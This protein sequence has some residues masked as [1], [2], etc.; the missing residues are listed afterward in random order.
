M[1]RILIFLVVVALFCLCVNKLRKMIKANQ[2]MDADEDRQSIRGNRVFGVLAGGAVIAGF[3]LWFFLSM[4]PAEMGSKHN[5]EKYTFNNHVLS[6]EVPQY[7]T[8]YEVSLPLYVDIKPNDKVDVRYF[9]D[10]GKLK[11]ITGVFV[12]DKAV[13]DGSYQL[14]YKEIKTHR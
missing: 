4:E 2:E 3:F 11:N 5:V 13:H 9:V 14:V 10:Q 7:R 6:F 12:N 1:L 8:S